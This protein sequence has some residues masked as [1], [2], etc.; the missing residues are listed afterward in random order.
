MTIHKSSYL[1]DSSAVQKG[2]QEASTRLSQSVKRASSGGSSANYSDQAIVNNVNAVN[3]MQQT[4]LECSTMLH[5]IDKVSG[6]IKVCY[7]IN[8]RIMDIANEVHVRAVQNTAVSPDHRFA[9]FCQERLDELERLLNT[10]SPIDGVS[11]MGEGNTSDKVVD[12]AVLTVPNHDDQPTD[13][14]YYVGANGSKNFILMDNSV[15]EY[16][17]SARDDGLRD[18]I[19]FLKM[20][21]SIEGYDEQGMLSDEDANILSAVK[22]GL[23]AVSKR[24]SSIK[25]ELG[26]Q[27]KNLDSYKDTV[28]TLQMESYE[29]SSKLRNCTTEDL[30]KN[31][32]EMNQNMMEV[33]LGQTLNAKLLEIR[34]RLASVYNYV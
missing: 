5:N 30:V 34:S 16:G 26:E 6:R 13:T 12:F 18:L 14:D 21:T 24:L 1:A 27:M 8:D 28:E 20:G 19:F 29:Q 31:L 33:E 10:Q 22:D 17:V 4:I 7:G 9:S 15:R 3:S 25:L 23:S 32:H 2:M 11:V